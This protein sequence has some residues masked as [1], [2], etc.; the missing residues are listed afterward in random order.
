MALNISDGNFEA[1]MAEGKPV[2]LDFWALWCGPCKVVSPYI[3]ELAEEYE[4]RVNIG[5]CDVDENV[6]LPAR[7]G[8]R[9]IPTIL[10]FKD[11]VVVDKLVG[12][13]TKAALQ[14]KVEAIL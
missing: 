13:T 11:G 7:F 2:V 10:F 4:G 14:A 3:E 1:I 8:V 12:A 9:N 6:E 5:K